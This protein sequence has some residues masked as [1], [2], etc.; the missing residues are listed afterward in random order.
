MESPLARHAA[1]PAELQARVLA[2]RTG[3]PF[4]VYQAEAGGQRIVV[5]DEHDRVTIGRRAEN[6]VALPWDTAVS[7]LH[8]VVERVGGEWTVVDDG[9][10]QN[11]TWIGTARL[12]GR[13]RLHDGDTLRV[14]STMIAFCDPRV[15][16]STVTRAEAELGQIVELTATQRRVLVALCR[17]F[18]DGA[19]L[20]SPA[21]NQAIAGEVFL[22][23]DAVKTHLRTLF[24]K[25]AIGD[26]P[27]NQKRMQLV[28]R[29]ML[30]GVIT[31]RELRG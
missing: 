26:L 20:A 19:G 1:T 25:F 14:G 29:A 13:R 28:E 27:Q 18:A 16:Q 7:R 2:E 22:S 6:A 4:L 31:P 8:A 11:G 10:S 5:L 3:Q 24:R 23:V 30:S 17:P 21:T 12:A 15:A 9:L